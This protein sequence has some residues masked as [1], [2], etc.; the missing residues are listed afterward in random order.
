[1]IQHAKCV[2]LI[3][4]LVLLSCGS[5]KPIKGNQ[6]EKAAV[7]QATNKVESYYRYERSFWLCDKPYAALTQGQADNLYNNKEIRINSYTKRESADWNA[8]F[9]EGAQQCVEDRLGID[10]T[11]SYHYTNAEEE[12]PFDHVVGFNSTSVI[13]V[14]DGFFFLFTSEISTGAVPKKA[15][16]NQSAERSTNAQLANQYEKSE[17]IRVPFEFTYDLV[18]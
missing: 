6:P 1:M 8:V 17:T 5:N 7:E 13:V 10:I 14:Q 11:S 4:P 18:T 9:Y 12:F 3:L 15:D 2:L 16:L